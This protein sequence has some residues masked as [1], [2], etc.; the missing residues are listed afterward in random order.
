MRGL[1]RGGVRP[2]SPSPDCIRPILQML[3]RRGL[4][5]ECTMASEKLEERRAAPRK[6][7]GQMAA[8]IIK[9]GDAPGYCLVTDISKT[10]VRINVSGF[11]VPDVFALLF[12]PDGPA[13]SGNYKVVWR[14]G[15]DLGAR[16]IGAVEPDV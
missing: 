10:G 8:I 14:N 6:P 13:Q 2:H 9:Q 7:F 1:V 11:K 5:V 16:F 4:R 3:R 15:P 12:R